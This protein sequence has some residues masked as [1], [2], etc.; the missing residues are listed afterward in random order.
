MGYQHLYKEP[1][2]SCLLLSRVKLIM[3]QDQRLDAS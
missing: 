3:I 2:L 1:T